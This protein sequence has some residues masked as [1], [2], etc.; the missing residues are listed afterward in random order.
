M[1][2][3]KPVR[4]NPRIKISKTGRPY[5]DAAELVRSQLDR[6]QGSQEQDVP[7]AATPQAPS[8][9]APVGPRIDEGKPND[10]GNNT[11]PQ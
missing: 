4:L 6:M 1:S 5:I 9:P 3:P 11:A 8:P 2:T 7:L 10:S